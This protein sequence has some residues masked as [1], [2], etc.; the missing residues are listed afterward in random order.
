MLFVIFIRVFC[1]LDVRGRELVF[2]CLVWVNKRLRFDRD[3]WFKMNICVWESI[4][5]FSLK[6]GFFVVVLMRMMV[7]FFM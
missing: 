7:L 6:D 3:K 5:E 2:D 1:V 4:V